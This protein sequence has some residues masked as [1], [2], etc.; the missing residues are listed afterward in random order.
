MLLVPRLQIGARHGGVNGGGH[1]YYAAGGGDGTA[2]NGLKTARLEG[3]AKVHRFNG[4]ADWAGGQLR[5]NL[6]ITSPAVRRVE[7]RGEQGAGL[8]VV[9]GDAAEDL[10]AQ[11]V[12]LLP[13]TRLAGEAALV[14]NAA[15]S[16]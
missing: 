1:G 13:P 5:P 11:G 9:A 6:R 3:E 10:L 2:G 16:G 15:P 4:V 12:G 14:A 8:G 7:G